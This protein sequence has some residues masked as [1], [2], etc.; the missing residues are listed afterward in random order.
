MITFTALRF[1]TARGAEYAL[2]TIQRLQQQHLI[3]LHDAALVTWP[4]GAKR[5]KT[6]HLTNLSGQGALDGAFWGLLFGIIFFV[7]LLGAAIGAATGALVGPFNDVGIDDEFIKQ[8]QAKVT[9]GTSA[10]VLLTSEEVT[11][12]VVIAL[13]G[14]G[15]EI[16]TTNLSIEQEEKLRQAFEAE[17]QPSGGLERNLLFSLLYSFG[18]TWSGLLMKRQSNA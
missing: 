3:V 2:E 7:P 10:L 5:P 6:K 12:R 13:S 4:P 14:T 16:I 17:V 8:M 18:L 9:E 1:S 15:L 11:D